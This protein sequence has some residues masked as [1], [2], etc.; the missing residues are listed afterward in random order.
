MHT[1]VIQSNKT[2]TK[3]KYFNTFKIQIFLLKSF[4]KKIL[5]SELTLN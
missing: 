3:Q 4:M 5:K 1:G 2:R